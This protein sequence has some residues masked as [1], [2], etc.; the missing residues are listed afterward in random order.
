MNKFL[1][2]FI[3]ILFFFSCENDHDPPEANEPIVTHT[4]F[5]GNFYYDP[6]SITIN[7]GD[8]IRWINDGGLHDVNGEINSLTNMAFDNPETFNSPSTSI[9]GAEIYR[10]AF[11]TVGVYNYDCSV[12]SHALNGMIGTITVLAIE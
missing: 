5:A 4:I 7:Q 1:V 6:P 10:H 12:G 2:F 9:V 11:N 8:E 3:P